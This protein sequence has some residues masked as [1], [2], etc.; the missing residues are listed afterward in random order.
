MKKCLIVLTVPLLIL[1][2][3]SCGAQS[4]KLEEMEV[5]TSE[6]KSNVINNCG[7]CALQGDRIYYS[8]SYDNG[9]LYSMNTDGS[10]NRKLN[11]DLCQMF[12]YPFLLSEYTKYFFILKELT[13][14]GSKDG[15]KNIKL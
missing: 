8:N 13:Y 12:Q 15:H 11:D 1:S 14:N 4:G 9:T 3:S 2:F 10:D 6:V 5:N 7:D